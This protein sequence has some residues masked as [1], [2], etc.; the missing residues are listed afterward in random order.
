VGLLHTH[1]TARNPT[2]VQPDRDRNVSRTASAVTAGG[3]AKVGLNR[4]LFAPT[5]GLAYLTR[6]L[7]SV[8]FRGSR[9]EHRSGNNS[10]LP[11][12]LVEF[13][14]GLFTPCVQSAAAPAPGF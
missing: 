3:L 9:C 5:A 8:A 12:K 1:Y 10:W 11:E 4:E 2:W 7:L 6:T 14:R 13:R